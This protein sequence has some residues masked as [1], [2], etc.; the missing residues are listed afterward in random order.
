LKEQR[1]EREGHRRKARSRNYVQY[2]KTARCDDSQNE[3]VQ[4]IIKKKAFTIALT[5]VVDYS[6]DL[7]LLLVIIF[8]RIIVLLACGGRK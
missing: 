4:R 8:E 3:D 5:C 6:E 7:F 2:N 1:Q